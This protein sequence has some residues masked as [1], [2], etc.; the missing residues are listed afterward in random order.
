MKAQKLT[1]AINAALAA[2][3]EAHDDDSPEWAGATEFVTLFCR[4][5][6]TPTLQ[7]LGGDA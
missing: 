1:A 5:I 6:E 4:E 2:M 7:T 3:A